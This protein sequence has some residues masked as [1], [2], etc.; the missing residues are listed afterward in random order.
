MDILVEQEI[1]L[2][3]Y[4]TRQSRTDIERLIHP[5]FSEVGKSGLCFDFASIVDMMSSEEPSGVRV[6]SQKYE[7]VQL[8]PSVQLLKYESA[9][10]TPSGEIT[11]Y[12]K[13]CSIWVFT[14]TCWQLKYHQ[15]TPCPAFDLI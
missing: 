12:A 4:E 11:D 14:G 5:N 3:Q 6:H 10:I 9:L 2:H 7:C 15:G 8:E 13:R 1:E